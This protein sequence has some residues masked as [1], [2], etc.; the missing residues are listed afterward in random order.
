[1]FELLNIKKKKKG[2]GGVRPKEASDLIY[3][4]LLSKLKAIIFQQ[5]KL[6]QIYIWNAGKKAAGLK[7]Q[8]A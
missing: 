8:R 1:M 4:M 5:L 2:G 3:G 6:V 7:K